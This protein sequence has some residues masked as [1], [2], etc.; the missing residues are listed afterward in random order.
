[1]KKRI[2]IQFT[3]MIAFL[4]VIIIAMIAYNLRQAGID[5]SINTAKS[6]SEVVKNGLTSHMING[7]MDQR[8]TF[9]NSIS[10]MQNV[11]KLW[12]VRSQAVTEQYGEGRENEQARDQ[13]DKKVVR[14][15]V[16]DFKL[17]ENFA[18][19][20]TIMRVTIPYLAN[21]EG[22]INCLNCHNVK[23]GETL[24]A[25]SIELNINELKQVS[26][27]SIY[28]IIAIT[29]LS[30][31]IIIFLTSN[32]LKPYLLLF[33]KIAESIKEAINGK[34]VKVENQKNI[35]EDMIGFTSDF[36]MLLDSYKVTFNDIDKKLKYFIGQS[37]S[38]ENK[39]PL[40]ESKLIITNLSNLY[41]FKKEIEQDQTKEEIFSRLTQVLQNQFKQNNFTVF[42]TNL[43]EETRIVVQQV[44]NLNF[45]CESTFSD[46]SL[47]RSARINNDVL[48][49]D[50]HNSC[51]CFTNE[52]HYYYCTSVN[53]NQNLLIIIN[54]VLQSKEELQKLKDNIPFIKSYLNEAAPSI[55]VK[56]LLQALKESA[57]RDGLT[58]L[59]NRKFLDEYIK[60]SIPQLLREKRKMAV[61]MLD[62]DH[63]K[64][65]NDEYGHDI[66]DLVLKE[67]ST[68]LIHNV[69]ESDLVVRFG[70][71]EFIVILNNIESA[72]NAINVANKIREE[73]SQH[74]IDVYAGTKL[75]KTISVGISVFPDDSKNF[76]TVAKNADI[77]LYEAKNKG[78]NQVVLFNEDQVSSIDL[79]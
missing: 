4:S 67:L 7:N 37:S 6:I 74:E 73:V 31:L 54:F 21:A 35:S 8:D 53:I 62:M 1:M 27:N 64:S 43:K 52:E 66:G 61:L 58:G 5:S 34:F 75:R 23:Y 63:F 51:P 24:G 15:G 68:I 71:E 78:R 20:E 39:T 3:T 16:M 17:Y 50:F 22:N 14:T 40:D 77:A 56:V 41:Q 55:E 57:F 2:I 60:K 72:Q 38:S 18:S 70:G 76:D 79:F 45:C 69:R 42:E 13:I 29:I 30:M 44:G 36:N 46:P 10:N 25:V 33:E 12:F 19:N 65:V 49:V 26:L 9:I 32:I 59:Y 11:K 28:I 48:S 47:C